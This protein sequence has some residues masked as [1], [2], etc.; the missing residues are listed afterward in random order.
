MV[1]LKTQRQEMIQQVGELHK[2]GGE[3][4]GRRTGGKLCFE[5]G[6]RGGGGGRAGQ[7]P[8][9]TSLKAMLIQRD[10]SSQVMN[11]IFGVCAPYPAPSL[12]LP[13]SPEWQEPQ[14]DAIPLSHL[15]R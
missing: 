3:A 14:T 15:P 1:P 10:S 9:R 13:P 2:P 11:L 12:D 8:I 4:E 6:P 7:G 5:A